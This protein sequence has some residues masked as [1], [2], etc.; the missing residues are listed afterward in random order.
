MAAAKKLPLSQLRLQHV[1]TVFLC[2]VAMCGEQELVV[3]QILP[4]WTEAMYISSLQPCL[5]GSAPSELKRNHP[6]FCPCA[7]PRARLRP[8]TQVDVSI[9][10]YP[11]GV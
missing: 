4:G 2:T 5:N 9:S 10:S 11:I 6:V 1:C 8:V 3:V 7:S